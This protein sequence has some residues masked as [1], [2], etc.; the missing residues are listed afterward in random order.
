MALRKAVFLIGV[1]MVTVSIERG[2]RKTA[3]LIGV[4]MVTVPS[5]MRNSLPVC[6]TWLPCLRA[7]IIV[8]FTPHLTR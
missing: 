5:R 1:A 2:E 6:Y 7:A 4:T 8:R 3:F